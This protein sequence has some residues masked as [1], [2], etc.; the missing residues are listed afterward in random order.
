MDKVRSIVPRLG[1]SAPWRRRQTNLD[2]SE[3]DCTFL[4]L[5]VPLDG[6]HPSSPKITVRWV[7]STTLVASVSD[8]YVEPVSIAAYFIFRGKSL[9]RSAG[10]AS[11]DI[12]SRT[13]PETRKHAA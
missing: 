6:E 12:A 7:K 9:R 5:S 4:S 2:L 10:M 1:F 13:M 11:I 3:A 8:V